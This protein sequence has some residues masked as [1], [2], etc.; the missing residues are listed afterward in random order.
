MKLSQDH[1]DFESNLIRMVGQKLLSVEYLEINYKEEN[2][3]PSYKTRFNEIDT[4]DFSIIFRTDK[5]KI[6]FYWDG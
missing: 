2:P 4:V 3:Q 5:D 6:E 1:I